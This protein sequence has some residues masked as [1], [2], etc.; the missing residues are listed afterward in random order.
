M[1]ELFY[2]LIIV[3]V[4]IQTA[5]IYQ[6]IMLYLKLGILLCKLYLIRA[7]SLQRKSFQ[8]LP[9]PLE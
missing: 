7:G 5:Y 9:F 2:I 4:F 8:W 6:V 3:V 1:M